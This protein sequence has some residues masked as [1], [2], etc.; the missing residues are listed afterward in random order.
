MGVG[1]TEADVLGQ[2]QCD[3]AIYMGKGQC[4]SA[5]YMWRGVWVA[6]AI[7]YAVIFFFVVNVFFVVKRVVM[8]PVALAWAVRDAVNFMVWESQETCGGPKTA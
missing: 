4:D 2:G 1:C 7:F 6:L 5:I 3:G 8:A